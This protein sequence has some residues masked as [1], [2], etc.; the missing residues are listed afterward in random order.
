MVDLVYCLTNLSVLDFLII[1][2]YIYFN[3]WLLI[4]CFIFSGDIYLSFSISLSNAAFS[5]SLS[6][7]SELFFAELLDIFKILLEILLP[8]KSSV[9]SADFWIALFQAVLSI[10]VSYWL[11]RSR[12]FWMYL[13]LKFLLTLL[14]IF[15]PY[16]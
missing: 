4:I 15:F 14:P 5:V 16:F 2:Y 1:C 8:G 7:V 6:I 3:L 12:S 13:L 9:A 11:S 10:F